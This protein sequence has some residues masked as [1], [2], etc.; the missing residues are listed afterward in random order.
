MPRPVIF[1]VLLADV[2]LKDV[3][4]NIHVQSSH[5]NNDLLQELLLKHEP[6]LGPKEADGDIFYRVVFFVRVGAGARHQRGGNS[7][8]GFSIIELS[9][10]GKNIDDHVSCGP[11]HFA[12]W[13]EQKGA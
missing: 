6:F 8:S 11:T 2:A 4:F 7:E 10:T 5:A 9:H 12:V 13:T 3:V 1:G